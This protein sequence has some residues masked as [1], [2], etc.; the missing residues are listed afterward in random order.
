[1]NHLLCR[2]SRLMYRAVDL[3]VIRCHPFEDVAYEKEVRKVRFL[4]KSDVAKIMA[5]KVNDKEAEQARRMFLFSCFTG[6][7]IAD[8]EYLKFSHIQTSADGRRYIR[9]ERQKTKSGVYRTVTSDRGG[10]P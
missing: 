2:L 10:D 9:K 5:L 8:M 6:L 1:M 4:Q 3:K 7:A